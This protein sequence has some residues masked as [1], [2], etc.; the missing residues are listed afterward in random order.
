VSAR[1]LAAT[2]VAGLR[3]AMLAA[4]TAQH[5][6]NNQLALTI[7]YA[8]LLVD[9]PRIPPDLRGYVSEIVSSA[10][11]AAATVDR[12]RRVT[13]LEESDAGSPEGQVLN[14][15]RSVGDDLD[16]ES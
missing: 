12:L 4:R 7:G 6:L 10:Q 9:D 14:L 1:T 5:L 2:V 16:T 3:R 15:V 13:R 11:A 8:D